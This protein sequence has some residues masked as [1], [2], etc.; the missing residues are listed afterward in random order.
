ME[1]L[2]YIFAL[3]MSI[4]TIACSNDDDIVATIITVKDFET[5]I[6]ENPVVDQEL[7]IIEANTNLGT[8]DYSIKS[9]DPTGAFAI[10]S[11]TGKLT[12]KD[13]TLFDYEMNPK[14]TAIVLIKSG[15]ESREAKVTVDLINIVKA[16]ITTKDFETT[17]DENPDQGK[18]LGTIEATT[19]EGE[20]TYTIKTEEPTG[21]FAIDNKTGK[22]TVKEATLFDYET[23]DQ[24]TAIVLIK[25]GEE[26]EEAKITVYLNDING[27]ATITVKNLE[28]T[29]NENPNEQEYLGFIEATTDQGELT[30]ILKNENPEGAFML[31]KDNG[32]EGVT[33]VHIQVKDA[34]LFDYEARN[35]LTATVLVI[36]GETSK[37]AT[38]K[39]NLN[40][41]AGDIS[42]VD[43]NFEKALL[44]H[45][46]PIIDT[47]GDGQITED[48]AKVVTAL[49]VKLKSIIDLSGIEY[50]TALT[51][52]DCSTNNNLTTLDLSKNI[53]LTE[54]DC[55]S[56]DI[57]TL[58]V[59]KNI[60]LTKLNCN[61]NNL[62]SID[63]SKNIKLNFLNTS[64][65]PLIDLDIS[66]N[67]VLETLGYGDE[68]SSLTTL[69]ISKN[70]KLSTLFIGYTDLTSIDLSNNT[71]L[72][73]LAFLFS[74]MTTLDLSN[75]TALTHLDFLG[76]TINTLDLSN[77][78]ALT[79][80]ACN[81]ANLSSLNLKNGN[82]ANL[83]ASFRNNPSLTC[84]EVDDPTA[85]YNWSKDDTAVYS[86][87]C[88]L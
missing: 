49:D 88:S 23:R 66:K 37:E 72:T 18:E 14:L 7:G 87:N 48:E 69:D 17:I 32:T 60:E 50:F 74:N 63:V 31:E 36:N 77:N 26:S 76:S 58:D 84:V 10:D 29:I 33:G 12:V 39:I 27:V 81:G 30:Y 1:N 40:D 3:F 78:V 16:T 55:S 47:N 68:N 59:S 54:L 57:T 73:R 11:K 28:V 45:T 53:A 65:N 51:T 2:K 34:A 6:K 43:P 4:L 8:L 52:L 5:V 85:N 42:F 79:N 70:T 25:S 15:G 24:L 21:A 80:L 71:E 44:E 62:T 19:D 46:D 41:I 61:G 35:Q 38:I 82:N 83:T 64:Q 56:N 22:L 75:N 67:I 86:S 13:A 20:L 9:E